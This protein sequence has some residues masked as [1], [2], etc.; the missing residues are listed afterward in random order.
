MFF[1]LIFS[2]NRA[3]D[4]NKFD[5]CEEYEHLNKIDAETYFI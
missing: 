3:A 1:S 5:N 4:Q 2:G